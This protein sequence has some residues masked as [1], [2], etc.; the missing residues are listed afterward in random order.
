MSLLSIPNGACKTRS[1]QLGNG[2]F[3]NILFILTVIV[4]IHGHRFKVYRLV[5]EVHKIADWV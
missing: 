4:G 3:I 2:L 5:L 1:T